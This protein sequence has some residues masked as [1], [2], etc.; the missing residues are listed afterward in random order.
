VI[1]GLKPGTYTAQATQQDNHGNTGKSNQVTFTMNAPSSVVS[2]PPPPP[3]ASFT[4]FPP[5]PTVGQSVALVSSSSDLSSPINAFAWDLAGNGPFKAAGPVLTTSFPTPGNHVVRLQVADTRGA[6]SV[7]TETIA[8][9]PA[10]LALM[11]PFPI[12]RI[13]GNQSFGGVNVSLLTVQAPVGARVSLTCRG[14]GCS[15]R[16]MSR[17]AAA[18]RHGSSTALIAFRRPEHRLH[19]GAILEIRV[20]AAGEIGKYTRFIIHRRKLPTREDSCVA[21]FDPR[22]IAC[23]A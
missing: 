10:P 21:A 6:S 3:S 22:P 2:P 16:S 18:S 7:A 14:R 17:V 23:P 13:A 5:T 12:V 15:R 9:S 8:V 20:A 11:Q 19:P 4:W 1:G